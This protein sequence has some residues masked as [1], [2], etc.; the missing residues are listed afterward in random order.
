MAVDLAQS[1]D[2]ILFAGKGGET[3]MN[4]KNGKKIPWDESAVVRE[5]IRNKMADIPVIKI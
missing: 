3:W 1:D 4:V 2:L 5:E